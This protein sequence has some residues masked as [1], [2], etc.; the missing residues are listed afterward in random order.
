MTTRK[1]KQSVQAVSG[2]SATK[3]MAAHVTADVH[4]C[5]RR[6]QHHPVRV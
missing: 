3:E 6:Q 4:L 2:E 5:L 1:K